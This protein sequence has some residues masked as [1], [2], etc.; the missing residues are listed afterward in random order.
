METGP[1]DDL[2]EGALRNIIRRHLETVG[3]RRFDR[4]YFSKMILFPFPN[5]GEV[6]PFFLRPPHP[7]FPKLELGIMRNSDY[8]SPATRFRELFRTLENLV[9][10][11]RERFRR[12]KS[13]EGRRRLLSDEVISELFHFTEILHRQQFSAE[14]HSSDTCRCLECVAIVFTA[15]VSVD[16]CFDSE[17]ERESE[18]G[19]CM[20]F[21]FAQAQ[22][23][24]S[25]VP[26]RGRAVPA[27]HLGP[28][29]RLE[30]R[31][32]FE[33]TW[34]RDPKPSTEAST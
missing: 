4:N 29:S 22:G 24:S 13:P 21:L 6:F 7:R 19:I 20:C 14:V 33:N 28:C 31:I 15:S 10:R 9:R 30:R 5:R 17:P 32:D 2:F 1:G 3:S 8:L 12:D 16:I 23:F 34:M 11:F 25:R 27:L 26:S 18:S